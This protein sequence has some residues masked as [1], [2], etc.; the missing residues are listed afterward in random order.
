MAVCASLV[1]VVGGIATRL[2]LVDRVGKDALT[3]R[4][5][6]RVGG[7]A[8]YLAFLVGLGLTFVLGI[9]RTF[10]PL[11]SS[12]LALL[13][14]GASIVFVIMLADDAAD[15]RWPVKL[16]W[17]AAA[18]LLVTLPAV[19]GP[20]HGIIISDFRAPLLGTIELPLWMAI[21]FS[22][23][24][25]TGMMNTINWID[26]LDGLAGGVTLIACGVLFL[27][28]Y[29][30]PAEFRQFT[31]ALLPLLL[32]GCVAG[33][34]PFNWHPA[35]I[36]MGDSGAMFLGF[37]LGGIAIIGGAKLATTLLALAIPILDVAWLIIARLLRG[38]SPMQRDT[39]HLHHRL[40][41]LGLSQRQVV[42]VYYGLCLV[43]GALALLLDDTLPK[44][45]ALIVAAAVLGLL[46][47][48]LAW[49]KPSV[50]RC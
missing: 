9:D 1:P 31:I 5:L 44:L 8:L 18:A 17:Q 21:P 49:R 42:A 15:L 4:P 30:Q 26:G 33:F 28:T 41:E 7:V 50:A 12:R 29:G 40:Y 34:L 39:R 38:H 48:V 11:E 27:H 13:T 23:F 36:I 22:V 16:G 47:L 37:A 45:I 20:R 32:A 3:T 25:L 46:L 2:G 14:I 19:W 24:W 6:P 43:F 10:D 35:R